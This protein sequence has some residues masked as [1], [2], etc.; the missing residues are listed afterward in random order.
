MMPS[1]LFVFG[2]AVQYFA[3]HYHTGNYFNCLYKENINC[4]IILIIRLTVAFTI[5][6]VVLTMMHFFTTWTLSHCTVLLLELL[7]SLL[8][9]LML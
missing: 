9:G 6:L 2:I 8:A 4:S 3:D 7:Y 1:L 5:S